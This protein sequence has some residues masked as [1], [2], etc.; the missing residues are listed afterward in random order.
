MREAIRRNQG[1]PRASPSDERGNQTQSRRTES[2]SVATIASAGPSGAHCKLPA[3]GPSHLM[4]GAIR[5]TQ[6]RVERMQV[7][8]SHLMSEAIR[9]NQG[10]RTVSMGQGPSTIAL[11]ALRVPTAVRGVAAAHLPR[12]RMQSDEI[13]RNQTQSGA[14]RRN[15]TQS[16]C[17]PRGRMPPRWPPTTT[18]SAAARNGARDGAP[19]GWPRPRMRG[20]GGHPPSRAP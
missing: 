18:R 3:V 8:P 20:R 17:L 13:R 11:P 10:H 1:T 9:H 19:R 14:I 16:A 5:H 12:G 4:R 15:Q 7:G 6:A 2:I